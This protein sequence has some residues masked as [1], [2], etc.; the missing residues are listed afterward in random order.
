MKDVRTK[1]TLLILLCFIFAM[2]LSVIADSTVGVKG[3]EWIKYE[4]TV[5]GT[6]PNP[7]PQ[8]VK[9]EILNVTGTTVNLR[10]TT[11]MPDGTE[12]NQTGTI[13]VLA[14]SA[15][16]PGLVI[17]TNSKAGD[18]INMGPMGSATI[19]GETTRTYAGASR[20]VVYS[21]FSQYG[22]QYTWYWDKQTGVAVEAMTTSTSFTSTAKATATNMW[23]GGFGFDWWLWVIII[24]VVVG[25]IT[26]TALILRRR[27]PP[28]T[29]LPPPPP[30]QT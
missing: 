5:S 3:G 12:N 27:K 25:A 11:H 30:P 15:I 22:T 10:M 23:G 17:P 28:V 9:L 7:M 19:A 18:S 2:D 13:D 26:A 4:L 20:T 21:S 14:G 1:F 29:P 16:L 8:W 24:L 6:P